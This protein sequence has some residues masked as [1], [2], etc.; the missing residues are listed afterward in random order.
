MSLKDYLVKYYSYPVNETMDSFFNRMKEDFINKFGIIV[1][2]DIDDGNP[3]FL[4]KYDMIEAVWSFELVAECRGC[5]WRLSPSG[6]NKVSNPWNK[7]WNISEGNCLLFDKKVFK[8]EFNNLS[9]VEKIDGSAIQV[10]FDG[11]IWRATT[12]GMI[13]SGQVSDFGISF[14]QLFWKTLNKSNGDFAKIADTNFCYL[15]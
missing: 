12:L 1:K 5:I 15:F 14:D 9:I 2:F 3:L 13:Q 4:F 6:W 10:F 7:F 8:S 11:K